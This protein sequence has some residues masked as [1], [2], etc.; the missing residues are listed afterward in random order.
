MLNV[1]QIL[2][3][4][5]ARAALMVCLVAGTTALVACGQRG[6]LYLPTD[7][8]AAGRATLPQ[9]MTPDS[10]RSSSSSSSEAAPAP[11]AAASAP[12]SNSTE[13]RK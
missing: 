6:A 7:P 8:A 3:S 4:T 2:V 12:A 10:L 9:L 11:A 5:R 13:P 1:R